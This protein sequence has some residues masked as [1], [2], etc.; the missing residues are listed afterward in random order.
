[1]INNSL[2]LNQSAFT[3]VELLVVIVVIGILAAITIVSYT[4][5]SSKAN[6][7]SLSSDLTNA[8]T[9]LKMF[10]VDNSAY[11][12]TISTDCAANPDNPTNKC[13]KLS[14]NTTYFYKASPT[15]HNF[16]CLEVTKSS[17]TYNIT[18]EGQLLAG[19]CPVLNLDAGNSLSYPGAGNNKWYDLSGNDNNGTLYGGVTYNAANGGALSF[20]GSSG[21]ADA[22]NG[23]SLNITGNL[24]IDACV[25]PK[26]TSVGTVVGKNGSYYLAFGS[27]QV[28]QTQH[29]GAGIYSGSTWAWLNGGT[30]ISINQWQCIAVRYDGSTEKVYLNGVEDGSTAK[31]GVTGV[32]GAAD[33]GYGSPGLNQ[34]FNGF[35]S[36]VRIYDRA[37]SADE[38]LQNFNALKGRYGL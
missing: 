27:S 5:I 3:I 24:T 30:L 22:G 10:N 20:D 19:P 34:Y 2:R 13:I 16:F 14:P 21:Y 4:G 7:A 31:T 18:Q 12:T 37:L 35:I 38:I 36:K 15:N 26:S 33:I 17:N 9:Q 29:I 23:A 6:I 1:M 28:T 8:S 32:G 25:Y 11:P